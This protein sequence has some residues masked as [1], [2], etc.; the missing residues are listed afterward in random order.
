MWRLCALKL[1]D[2][3]PAALLSGVKLSDNRPEAGQD[4]KTNIP[5]RLLSLAFVP[6]ESEK[7]YWTTAELW[8]DRVNK[9]NPEWEKQ[10]GV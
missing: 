7:S 5:E 3:A 4:D 9:S 1:G 10:F 6:S 2:F 8:P